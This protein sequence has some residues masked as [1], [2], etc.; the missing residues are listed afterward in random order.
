M[1]GPPAGHGTKLR[2]EQDLAAARG[3]GG[4]VVGRRVEADYDQLGPA[5]SR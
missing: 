1:P 4:G 5:A 3:A 2:L